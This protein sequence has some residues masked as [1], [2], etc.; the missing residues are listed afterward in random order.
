MQIVIVLLGTLAFIPLFIV[1]DGWVLS[2]IWGWIAVPVF[3]LPVL[4][5]AQAVGITSIITYFKST[6]GKPNDDSYWMLRWFARIALCMTIA[7]IAKQ[8]I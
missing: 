3:H 8:F 1:L 2:I 4:S 7:F 6:K 5:I